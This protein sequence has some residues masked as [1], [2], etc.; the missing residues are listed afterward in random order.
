M[1][2]RKK[3]DTSWLAYFHNTGHLT[4]EYM[5][6]YCKAHNIKWCANCRAL[7]DP[8][9]VSQLEL[10]GDE[11]FPNH[12]GYCVKCIYAHDHK[13]FKHNPCNFNSD[14]YS[15]YCNAKLKLDTEKLTKIVKPWIPTE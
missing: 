2:C 14:T 11:K 5:S 8:P 3:Q 6:C 15:Q 4:T 10:Y 9:V 12:P 7:V 13:K 1:K